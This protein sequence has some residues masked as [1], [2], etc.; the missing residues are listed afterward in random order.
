M[1]ITGLRKCE[2]NGREKEENK[3]HHIEKNETMVS[4]EKMELIQK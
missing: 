4:R 3:E 2:Y 1:R